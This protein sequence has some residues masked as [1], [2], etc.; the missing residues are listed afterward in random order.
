MSEKIEINLSAVNGGP[1]NCAP[2]SVAELNAED[3]LC[4]DVVFPWEAHPHGMRAFVIGDTCGQFTR[5][6]CLV[7]A[8]HTQDAF[9]EAVDSGKLE[10]L[11][12]EGD[13]ETDFPDAASLG[14]AG[15]LHCL[16][17]AWCR[18]VDLRA[19]GVELLCKLAEA[20]GACCDNLDE[21]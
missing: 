15:E 11:L 18:E 21:I 19:C 6:L 1:F 8:N 5:A 9:D 13:G 2:A 20:R 14:N 7:W 4:N 3:V 12:V 17:D 16:D 10:S